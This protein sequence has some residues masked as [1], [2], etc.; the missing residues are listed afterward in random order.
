M[1]LTACEGVIAFPVGE[2]SN[3][4]R[5]I[6]LSSQVDNWHTLKWTAPEGEWK[7]CYFAQREMYEGTFATTVPHGIT[8]KY[9]DV[10]NPD[11]VKSFIRVTHR[12][13]L[14]NTP[15]EL[16]KHIKASFTD[17]PLLVAPY[18]GTLP[19]ERGGNQFV[20]DEPFFTDRPV[21]VIWTSDFVDKFKIMKGY[22]IRPHLLSLFTGET[23]QDRYVRQDYWEVTSQLYTMSYHQQIADWCEKNGIAY[24]GHLLAEEGLHG[25]IMFEGNVM[26]AIRPMQIPGVDMLNSHPEKMIEEHLMAPKVVSSVAHLTG[27]KMVQCESSGYKNRRTGPEITVDHMRGQA[28]ILYTMGVNHLTLFHGWSEIGEDKFREYTD[29]V[30]RL[31]LMFQEADHI[32]DVAMLYPVRTGWSWYTPHSKKDVPEFDNS[33]LN[34]EMSRIAYRFME[35]GKRLVKR[36]VDFDLVDERAIQESEMKSGIMRISDESFKVVVLAGIE[37][38]ELETLKALKSFKNKGGVII[39]V[40]EIPSLADSEE[41]QEEFETISSRLFNKDNLLTNID[42]LPKAIQSKIGFDLFL[43]KKND[44]ISYTHYKKNGEDLYFISNNRNDAVIVEPKLKAKGPWQIYRPLDGSINKI[45]KRLKIELA[46]YEGIF[47]K[48]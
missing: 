47:L 14:R 36:Q 46:P 4:E 11:A 18:V 10:L 5:R 34:R 7:V 13:Y 9:I 43:K 37:A 12:S 22:D 26:S 44:L 31:G 2:K 38:M 33:E 42:Q 16:W 30:G 40:W 45:G 35:A 15:K 23:T 27:R 17:E 48:N 21:S 20:L 39:P 41:N 3:V 8:H 6:D 1:T 24:T 25:S 28:N 32:C 29:Y 19:A